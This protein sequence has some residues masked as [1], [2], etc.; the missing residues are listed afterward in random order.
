MTMGGIFSG[1]PPPLSIK[2]IYILDMELI[3]LEVPLH[4]FPLIYFLL[5]LTRYSI[6]E[7]ENQGYQKFFLLSLV[8]IPL[9][10]SIFCQGNDQWY[11]SKI[12]TPSS[13][14]VEILLIKDYILRHHVFSSNRM[15][16]L[17]PLLG[18]GVS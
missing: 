10:Y 13:S 1:C 12:V 14:I 11:I 16:Y 9:L 2:K 5:F 15:I 3:H 7:D 18:I 6:P 4:L 8:L 17:E